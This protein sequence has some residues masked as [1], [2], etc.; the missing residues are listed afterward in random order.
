MITEPIRLP[1]QVL[2]NVLIY[3]LIDILFFV[4]CCC[5]YAYVFKLNTFPVNKSNPNIKTIEIIFIVLGKQQA[6][7]N[8]FLP[9]SAY[10]QISSYE[11]V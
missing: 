5:V 7:P 4:K 6:F 11:P 10:L 9:L 3:S 8:R 1:I 2:V